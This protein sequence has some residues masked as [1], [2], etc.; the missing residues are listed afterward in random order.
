ML[1]HS[2][3]GVLQREVRSSHLTG[4]VRP[5]DLP[6]RYEAFKTDPR[7]APVML[8]RQSFFQLLAQRKRSRR[9]GIRLASVRCQERR[10]KTINHHT[11]P[12]QPKYDRLEG[13]FQRLKTND[14]YHFLIIRR[15]WQ[16]DEKQKVES[17]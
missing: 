5:T 4:A 10:P 17:G 11:K 2:L 14:K 13:R 6:T 9:N 1:S 12:R 15:E 3:V 7:R 16:L 8:T